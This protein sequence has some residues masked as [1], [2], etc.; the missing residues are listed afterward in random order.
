MSMREGDKVIVSGVIGE[1]GKPVV[2]TLGERHRSPY[3]ARL[4]YRDEWDYTTPDG[5]EGR[6]SADDFFPAV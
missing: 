4:N 1:D 5:H 6:R 2:C 3:A